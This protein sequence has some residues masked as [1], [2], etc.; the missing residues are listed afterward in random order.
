MRS[1][2]TYSFFSPALL[3]TSGALL[4]QA[5]RQPLPQTAASTGWTAVT[6]RLQRLPRGFQRRALYDTQHLGPVLH[7]CL[8]YSDLSHKN[9]QPEQLDSWRHWLRRHLYQHGR[10]NG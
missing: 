10:H 4:T 3:L 2:L 1:R 9:Q 7:Q 5:A 6:T 8:L